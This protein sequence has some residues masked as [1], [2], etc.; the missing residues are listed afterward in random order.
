MILLDAESFVVV[1]N[2]DVD[3]Y[4]RTS[5]DFHQSRFSKRGDAFLKSPSRPPFVGEVV[6]RAHYRTG[7]RFAVLRTALKRLSTSLRSSSALNK[8]KE[9]SDCIAV[10]EGFLSVATTYSPT[11]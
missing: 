7:L 1:E 4:E 6:L 5:T 2:F 10:I 9:S 11:W 8:K 3:E